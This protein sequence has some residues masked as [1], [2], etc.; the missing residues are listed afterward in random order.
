MMGANLSNF[1][2]SLSAPLFHLGMGGIFG[3][4]LLYW[5]KL[6]MFTTLRYLL[7]LGIFT[8]VAGNRLLRHIVTEQR[9]SQE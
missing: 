2:L 6:D 7:F 8:F 3:L 5:F 1:P 9:K 4:Y